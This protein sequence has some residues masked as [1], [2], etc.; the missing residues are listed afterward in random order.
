MVP[1]RR[2]A[3]FAS[4]A[5]AALL[6]AATGAYL[7]HSQDAARQKLRND[8]ANR[9]AVAA[10]LTAGVFRS[11]LPGNVIYAKAT[12]GGPESSIQPAI[13][14]DRKTDPGERVIVL[15]SDGRV[16]GTAPQLPAAD[17][18][19]V[20]AQPEAKRALAGHLAFSGVLRTGDGLAVMM[21]VPFH[22]QAGLRVWEVSIPVAHISALTKGYLTSSLALPVGEARLVDANGAVVASSIDRR[23][24]SEVRD[25]LSGRTNRPASVTTSGTIYESVPVSGT[26]WRVVFSAPTDV[27]F[28]PLKSSRRLAWQLFGAFVLAII[29]MVGL[30]LWAMKSSERLAYQRLH[31]GLTGL[32]NRTLFMKCA[33]RALADVRTRGGRLATLFIDLDC[34][35]PINDEHGHAVGDAVLAAVAERLT[36]AVRTGDVIGRFGGD[37][38]L[39]LCARLTD[40]HQALDIARRIQDALTMPYQVGLVELSVGCSIGIAFYPGDEPSIDASG[41]IQLADLAMYEA[42]KHGRARIEVAPRLTA[43]A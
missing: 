17:S 22:V 20:A 13:E 23:A 10:R 34:F 6:L 16:L 38:F 5:L 35:K 15:S 28:A 31:D 14:A 8:F 1:V 42:K 26:N 9:A 40:A 27:L 24:G 25:P 19:A 30:A 41:L 12:Y 33:D 2:R 39:V 11:S 37:E 3:M 7:A 21:C 29:G 32:P 36:E 18:A 43:L 4:L